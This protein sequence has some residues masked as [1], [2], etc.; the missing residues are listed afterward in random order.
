MYEGLKCGYRWTGGCPVTLVI[1]AALACIFFAALV[2]GEEPRVFTDSDLE[3]IKQV[4][5]LDEES[6]RRREAEVKSYEEER[7]TEYRQQSALEKQKKDEQ[8]MRAV[9]ENMKKS[10][11]GKQGTGK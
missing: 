9:W 10:L 2:Y 8:E 3:N 4:Q 5:S 6:V 1:M 7:E 11:K